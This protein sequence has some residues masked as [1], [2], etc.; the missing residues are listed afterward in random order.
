MRAKLLNGNG[1][2]SC[3]QC[4][5]FAALDAHRQSWIN[6]QGTKT[7][8]H[9]I[10]KWVVHQYEALPVEVENDIPRD[11]DELFSSRQERLVGMRLKYPNTLPMGFGFLVFHSDGIE[12]RR[13]FES[14]RRKQ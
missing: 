13:W 10:V 5:P 3:I 12:V 4:L 14:A 11:L 9:F 1:G 7:S 6:E 2:L 8:K